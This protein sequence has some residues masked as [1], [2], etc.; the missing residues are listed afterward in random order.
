MKT[1]KEHKSQIGSLPGIVST[2]LVVAILVA[3][4]FFILQTFLEEDEFSNTAGAVTNET[5]LTIINTSTS[6]VAHA[7]DT[8]FNTFAISACYGNV[9]EAG[10]G[11]AIAPNATIVAANYTVNAD[12]GVITAVGGAN[13]TDVKCSYTYLYGETSYT[14][15]ND[16]ITAVRT[17]PDLLGLIILIAIIGVVL[18]VIFNI[19]PGA[20]VSGA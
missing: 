20:R 17:I 10:I 5:G 2:V 18:V 16:T 3:A 13:Y 11:T 14:S 6:T 12:T 1:L 9:T 19:I 7:T 8:A 15:L 4:G